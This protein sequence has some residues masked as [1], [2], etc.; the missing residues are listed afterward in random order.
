MF[1]GESDVAGGFDESSVVAAA[2][3][4]AGAGGGLDGVF[5]AEA[6]G[7]EAGMEAFESDR[8]SLISP[9]SFHSSICSRSYCTQTG[10]IA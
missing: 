2:G 4:G 1:E 7:V 8:F 9:Y 10:L 5:T 6:D 3:G